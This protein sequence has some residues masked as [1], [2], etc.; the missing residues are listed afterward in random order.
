M[1][2]S[3]FQIRKQNWERKKLGEIVGFISGNQSINKGEATSNGKYPAYSASGQD[4][5]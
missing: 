4:I 2:K 1:Q 5:F 3:K